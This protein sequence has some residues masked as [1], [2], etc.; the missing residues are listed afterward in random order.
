MGKNLASKTA[1]IVGVLLVFVFGFI[2]I[3][4]GSLKESILKRINLGL[5]LKGGTHL[6]LEVHVDEAVT[7]TTDRDVV[8][9]GTDL[10]KIGITGASIGKTD[11][12]NPETIVISGIP[13][14]K[15]G[16]ARGV[17][18]GNDYSTYDVATNA[19]G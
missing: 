12:A 7:S 11:P 1:F 16:D 3:P 15:L 8:R 14:T 6:V 17:I 5:D 18:R 2:G 13:P 9:L 19:A 4:H 10:E